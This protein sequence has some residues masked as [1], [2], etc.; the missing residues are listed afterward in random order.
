MKNKAYIIIASGVILLL[1]S[2]AIKNNPSSSTK[3]KCLVQ[4]TN[5][6][7]EGA[8]IAV[9]VINK[10]GKYLKTLQ[11]LGDDEEWY[12]D[13]KYW[14]RFHQ[15]EMGDLDG[16]TGET[17]SGGERTVLVLEIDN[18]LINS[19][20]SIRFETAVEEE[21]Y[22]QQ[23]LE[24]KLTPNNLNLKHEGK[25]YIRYVKMMSNE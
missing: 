6:S 11:I 17:I 2:F 14:Y 20:N 9:S 4:L 7:G 25:G 18:S 23:D 16:I 1:S 12:P 19:E 22:H 3:Y 13:V 24:F 15:E 21:K 8:Y 10:E 5:Y